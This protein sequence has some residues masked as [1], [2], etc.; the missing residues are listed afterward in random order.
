MVM[1][2]VASREQESYDDQANR[3]TES[4]GRD[5][6]M[7]WSFTVTTMKY[8]YCTVF[9]VSRPVRRYRLL[10]RSLGVRLGVVVVFTSPFIPPVGARADLYRVHFPVSV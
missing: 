1:V 2:V 6:G 5:R 3:L 4:S 9:V 8:G 10:S 7:G